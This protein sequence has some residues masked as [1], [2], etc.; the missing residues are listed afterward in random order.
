MRKLTDTSCRVRHQVQYA[1]PIDFPRESKK[2]AD[3]IKLYNESDSLF[4]S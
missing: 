4:V 2:L 1:N 3:L